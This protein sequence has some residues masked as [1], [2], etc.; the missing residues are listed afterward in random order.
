MT[1]TLY[2]AGLDVGSAE[3][4]CVIGLLENER[5]RL[6]GYGAVASGGWDKGEIKSQKAV[7]DSVL[8]ALREAEAQAQVPVESVVVGVGGPSVRG[9]NARGVVDMGRPREIEQRDINRAI[10]RASLVQL[11]DD[12]MVLQLFP[13]DFVVDDHP[14][15]RDPRG[16]IG[17]RL[18]ANVHLVTVS[19][20]EHNTLVGAVN[21]A[22][23]TVEETVFEPLAASYAAILPEDRREGV[24]LVDIGAE[25]TDL[26]IYYGDALQLATSLRVC[27]DHFT[28]D[29]VKMLCVGYEDAEMLKRQFG[30]AVASSTAENSLVELP[31]MES[32]EPRETSRKQ[33]NRYLEAR[34]GEVFKYVLREVERVGMERALIGGVVL[35]GGASMLPGICDMAESILN[36]PARKGLA[37]GILDWPEEIDT[38]VWTTVAGLAMYSA[39]LKMQTELEKKTISLLGRILR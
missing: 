6:L 32:R 17:S 35:T 33:V 1:K 29:L 19:A 20:Q 15:H 27:G 2:P 22:H 24:A 7:T 36:C 31:S 4:R 8:G 9:A 26:V 30:C 38:A 18:D 13:Q 5:V 14:G 16:M 21:Q 3:T 23:L 11:M 37:L 25:S 28:R 39:R 34:A 10:S 12:R